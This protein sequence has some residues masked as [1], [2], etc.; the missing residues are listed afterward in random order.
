MWFI[1]KEGGSFKILSVLTKVEDRDDSLSAKTTDS[2]TEKWKLKR[3][4]DGLWRAFAWPSN[5]SFPKDPP[6]PPP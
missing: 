4:T 1:F 2:D 5:A 6:L 3:R